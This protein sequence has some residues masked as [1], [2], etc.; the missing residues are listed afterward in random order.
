VNVLQTAL[1]RALCLACLHRNKQI[2]NRLLLYKLP[3]LTP[4][5]DL[6]GKFYMQVG[7]YP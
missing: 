1:L 7:L 4:V 3:L 5:T 2:A 6:P